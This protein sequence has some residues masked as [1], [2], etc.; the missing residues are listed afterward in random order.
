MAA[1]AEAFDPY[2]IWLAIPPEDQP[3]DHYRLLGVKTFETNADVL[4]SA[5]DQ[6]MS[7]VRSF[8]AGK[9]SA[10]SQKL[11]NE[12][13]AARLCLLS[14]DKRGA[15]DRALKAKLAAA[16]PAPPAAPAPS[17]PAPR[18]LAKARPLA[19]QPL[20]TP[21]EPATPLGFDPLQQTPAR[22]LHKRRASNTS[23][24]IYA[25]VGLGMFAVIAIAWI[26][27]G[28]GDGDDQP[29]AARD[30]ANSGADSRHNEDP[31]PA[32]PTSAPPK[33]NSEPTGAR[34]NPQ[35]ATDPAGSSAPDE[36]PA[37]AGQPA[38]DLAD[39]MPVATE[40]DPDDV[41]AA[42]SP[43]ADDRAEPPAADQIATAVTEIQRVLHDDFSAA[44]KSA[45]RT[46]LAE[47]L[48][49]LVPDS[50]E[51]SERFALLSEARRLAIS[52]NNPA[53]ALQAA[54]SLSES[55]TV[56]RFDQLAKTADDL[57][58]RDL[59]TAA[60][61]EL[62]EALEPLVEQALSAGQFAAGRRL[63]AVGAAA[64]R[65]TNQAEIAKTLARLSKELTA[66]EKLAAS[67]ADARTRLEQNPDDP[68]ANETLG[69]YLC[70]YAGDW[71][72]GL[73]HLARAENAALRAVAE[74][75]TAADPAPTA[76]VKVADA[77]WDLAEHGG[78]D[79]GRMRARAGYWYEQA[80]GELT[81]LAKTRVE[82]RLEETGVSQPSGNLQPTTA[83]GVTADK[84][85]VWNCHNN[86]DK[87]R[88]M[89]SCTVELRKAGKVV[90]SKKAIKLAWSKD[91]EPA[92]T[93]RLPKISFDALRVASD[94]FQNFGL[95]LCEVEIFRGSNNIA[96]GKP[97][98]ASGFYN[99]PPFPPAT[100]V[101]GIRNSSQLHVGYW[102][103]PNHQPGW[104]EVQVA[105]PA[106]G[107]PVY[108]SDLPPTEVRIFHQFPLS[109]PMPVCGVTSAH[110]LFVHPDG[111]SSSYVAFALGR[112]YKR[113]SGAAAI[114]DT[115]AKSTTP[116]LF[117]VVGDG[118]ELWR[119]TIQNSGK[120]YPL[121]VSVA[122][123][124]KLELFVDCPGTQ[125]SAHAIWVDLELTPAGASPAILG[126]GAAGKLHPKTSDG[127]P[128]DGSVTADKLVIW[129][130]NNH[131]ST[132]Q[133][134]LG[135]NVELRMDGKVVWSKL[136]IPL[137]WSNDE[138]P[139]TTIPLPKVPFDALRVQATAYHGAGPSLCEVEIFRGRTNIARG[140]PVTESG[141]HRDSPPASAVVDG[142]AN[143]AQ[144]LVG[145][146]V[147]PDHQLAW[148][149][150]QVAP[151]Q[152]MA[153]R[154]DRSLG[155][156]DK[157]APAAPAR[158]PAGKTIDLLALAD[159]A[160][161]QLEAAW[162]KT[163]DGLKC[164]K[165]I[166]P[167]QFP[168]TVS[169]DYSLHIE[170]T[171]G[172][173]ND[174]VAVI[175]PALDKQTALFVSGY[176]GEVS[177]LSYVDGKHLRENATSI[178]PSIL[179]NGKRYALDLTVRKVKDQVSI[180][181]M[182]GDK[183]IVDWQGA[184]T[185]LS[186]WPDWSLPR[187]DVIGLAANEPTIFHQA[188]LKMLSGSATPLDEA[189]DKTPVIRPGKA[190]GPSG[191]LS[192]KTSD[193]QPS[194]A[195][196]GSVTADKL[197]V[198]NCKS[199]LASD[200][201][202]LSCNVELR[203]AGEVVWS[204]KRIELDWKYDD[205]PAT[206]I[207]LPK[208]AFDA[209]RVETVA[210]HARGPALC[211]VEILQDSVNL[212]RGKPVASDGDYDARFPAATIVDGIRSSAQFGA[213]YWCAPE[214]QRGWIEI[215][216]APPS[217]SGLAHER[218]PDAL[219]DPRRPNK[220][221]SGVTAD[222]LLLWNC[223]CTG[224]DRG[225]LSCNVELRKG[226][227]AVWVKK[228]IDLAWSVDVEPPTKIALPKVAF[229]AVRV[230]TITHHGSGPALCEVEIL[231]GDDNLAIGKPVVT[232]GSNPQGGRPEDIV[233]GCRDS[234]AKTSGFWAAP[235]DQPNAWIEVQVAP[236]SAT[237]ANA[238]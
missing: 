234:D 143:S 116:L 30:S 146:W 127:Q 204:K 186:K 10:E 11:L 218:K 90:W 167:L 174:C 3:P 14:P 110:S 70:L 228:S 232:S 79:A 12:L 178:R 93:I 155:K 41:D 89:L 205:E 97:V 137:A 61:K 189:G 2:H 66:G 159:P 227:R 24:A 26:A 54:E 35:P 108:L 50:S 172:S 223:H 69:K 80:A 208:T 86:T 17:A 222:A 117:R 229:D 164:E 142:I 37:E 113:L 82:K 5:A 123:V 196:S 192:P 20:P 85:V 63:A 124:A 46:A 217:G 94:T 136:A 68:N 19:A 132:F 158:L 160:R 193:S 171:R 119:E 152:T 33:T 28:S 29:I 134:M 23:P 16:K 221:D 55:F 237:A 131:H 114:D 73:P 203:K 59:P 87:D 147:A 194:K 130:S 161:E 125:Q 71:P 215:Q 1:M 115:V 156:P 201:G 133:G 230:Q 34:D 101:D 170:F 8:Q 163:P 77:W 95:A 202:M 141:H 105:P 185:S 40:D 139:A 22:R 233:D 214:R 64:A 76:V 38:D 176:Y 169:G 140:K 104:V 25:G 102:L 103:A 62:V 135:C 72:A 190:S 118:K 27:I 31:A 100:V 44:K 75:E 225:I 212:A 126:A 200:R 191:K 67:A 13:A 206:T 88:G 7:H 195:S 109:Q 36:A 48:L 224:K 6:R 45:D 207:P 165:Q 92:T 236:P 32:R 138:E 52:A 9:H 47:K 107:R 231:R 168:L 238:Q 173:G 210:Y 39:E 106:G 209:V 18:P 145:Y 96:R 112:E 129:N 197:V 183:T 57:G 175:F 58:E 148:V 81:G 99:S 60:R 211:E 150:V 154:G 98:A 42:E 216:L 91:E 111:N 56:D 83:G 235:D 219:A 220:A 51:A 187:N 181:A 65:K 149:E 213:G 162:H 144:Q 74:L 128:R 4:E 198:W 182:L 43:P 53:L 226:G 179:E 84:L 166:T 15:Y 180:R 78:A 199:G 21:A 121:S 157:A 177:G 188:K 49:A 122:R 120:K 184:A 151:P 153:S